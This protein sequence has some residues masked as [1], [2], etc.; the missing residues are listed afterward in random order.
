MLGVLKIKEARS[1]GVAVISAESDYRGQGFNS[2]SSDFVCQRDAN[3]IYE[4]YCKEKVISE[5]Q[6]THYSL[7]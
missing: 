6:H 3:N 1:C 5:F 4:I 7:L 2:P